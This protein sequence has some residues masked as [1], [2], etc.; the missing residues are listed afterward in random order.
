MAIQGKPQSVS[1]LLHVLPR[2]G[3]KGLLTLVANGE[4]GQF[5]PTHTL[6]SRS[7][8]IIL[9]YSGAVLSLNSHRKPEPLELE[10]AMYCA[11]LDE[12]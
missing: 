9:Q 4:Q 3:C 10:H 8:R 5:L 7:I 2:P 1:S 11:E 12:K 6:E